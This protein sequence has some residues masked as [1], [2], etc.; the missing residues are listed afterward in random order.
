MGQDRSTLHWSQIGQPLKHTAR[1]CCVTIAPSGD[2]LA[3]ANFDVNLQLWSIKNTLSTT[4]GTDSLYL[5]H[6]RKVKLGQKLYAEALPDAEK[7]IELNP[8]S[9]IGYELKFAALRGA[10]RY[11]DAFEASTIMLSMLD[12]AP[13]LALFFMCGTLMLS[14]T[15]DGIAL[16]AS[17]A[18]VR[19]G[20]GDNELD[21]LENSYLKFH[22]SSTRASLDLIC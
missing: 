1:V 4:L 2:L 5:A 19:L 14:C 17:S 13:D 8:L 3:R 9:Y 21:H 10:Q 12:D 7:V 6:H 18:V 15:H 16:C 11:D 22:L 20:I